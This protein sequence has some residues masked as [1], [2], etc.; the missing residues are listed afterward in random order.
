MK[1][2]FTKVTFRASFLESNLNNILL[3]FCIIGMEV[4]YFYVQGLICLIAFLQAICEIWFRNENFKIHMH[5]M[6]CL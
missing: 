3:Y 6:Q 4:K 5:E 2:Q 1:E